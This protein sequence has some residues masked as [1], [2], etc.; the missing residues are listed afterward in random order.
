MQAA[1]DLCVNMCFH[2]VRLHISDK[3]Q[4][5]GKAIMKLN[6]FATKWTTQ[7]ILDMNGASL[8]V[9]ITG[10]NDSLSFKCSAAFHLP[11]TQ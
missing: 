11:A 5:F 6:G 9:C 2:I 7:G 8:Y 10:P 4:I 3:K 1:K